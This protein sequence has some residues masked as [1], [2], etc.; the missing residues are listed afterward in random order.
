MFYVDTIVNLLRLYN[1][2]QFAHFVLQLMIC[3]IAS[4]LKSNL[5][6]SRAVP[7]VCSCSG[8]I[9]RGCC[10]VCRRRSS[11]DVSS[12]GASCVALLCRRALC[13]SASS[14][15]IYVPPLSPS[16]LTAR[17]CRS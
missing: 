5:V 16:R 2:L 4:S 10:T 7:A 3:H 9:L 8:L 15:D 14:N 17:A 11:R 13:S 12:R 6:R 1:I